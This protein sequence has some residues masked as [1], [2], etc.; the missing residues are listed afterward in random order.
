MRK[1]SVTPQLQHKAERQVIF[2][3]RKLKRVN[4]L[5]QNTPQFPSKDT[6]GLQ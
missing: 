2:T 4:P 3:Q 1:T 6:S 5:G